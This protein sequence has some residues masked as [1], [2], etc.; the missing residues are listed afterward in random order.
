MYPV[1]FPT[2]FGDWNPP[3]EDVGNPPLYERLLEA[4][5]VHAPRPGGAERAPQPP[6]SR[7]GPDST[8]HET[9]APKIRQLRIDIRSPFPWWQ[10]GFILSLRRYVVN[11]LANPPVPTFVSPFQFRWKANRTSAIAIKARP[12]NTAHQHLSALQ[13]LLLQPMACTSPTV[14]F[15][16]NW[17]PTFYRANRPPPRTGLA[18]TTGRLT[19]TKSIHTRQRQTGSPG[20][21][22]YPRPLTGQATLGRPIARYWPRGYGSI[23]ALSAS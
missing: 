1:A 3:K 20:L 4:D 13:P 15:A 6:S 8:I 17:T 14:P 9:E 23:S 21:R 22:R 2:A 18:T 11:R 12:A 19:A 7:S 5:L 10:R 16:A